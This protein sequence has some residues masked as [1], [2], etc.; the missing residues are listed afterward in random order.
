MKTADKNTAARKVPLPETPPDPR[1]TDPKATLIAEW[2]PQPSPMTREEI[3][4]IVIEQIG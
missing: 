3:R 4:K 1:L 2:A